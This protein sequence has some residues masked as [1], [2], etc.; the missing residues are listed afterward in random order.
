MNIFIMHFYWATPLP[1]VAVCIT[2]TTVALC[3]AKGLGDL[4]AISN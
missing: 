4:T 1:A 2:L 3:N